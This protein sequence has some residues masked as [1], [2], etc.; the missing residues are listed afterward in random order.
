[1]LSKRMLIGLIFSMT[2]SALASPPVAGQDGGE[3]IAEVNGQ[4]LTR[5]ELE[6]QKGA[7]LLQARYK[8]YLAE[9]DALE[10]FIDDKLLEI[11]A[12]RENVSVDELLKRHVTSQVKIP[13]EEQLR[14]YYEALSPDQPYEEVRDKILQS[15]RDLREK[16]A[17]AA[18]VK[19]LRS[20]GSVVIELSPPSSEIAIGNAP[21]RG[22]ETAPVQ[23][24]EF[25]DYQCP[26]CQKVHP[27]LRKLEQQ[28]VGKIALVF[29]DF[30]LPMHSS[31]EKASEAAHCAGE[32]GKFWEFHDALFETKK[33]E[34]AELKDLARVL[35]LDA[36]RFD[37]CLDSGEQAAAVQK[38][39]AEAQHLGLTGTPSFFINGHF[40]SGAVGYAKLRDAVEQSLAAPTE[41]ASLP[42]PK[43]TATQ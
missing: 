25:A 35:K 30:P 34:T 31:A 18:Y 29:K 8:Y 42:T 2:F 10:G 20:E 1:M 5:A 13:T 26:Y 23:L 21:R 15:V 36:T 22:A 11:Q 43:Q 39:V 17:R 4:K 27:E 16:N 28:Y 19:A 41:T 12:Q 6:K 7:K 38:D 37:Q 40:L 9:R 33:L 32:Q 14:F 3:T 24:V